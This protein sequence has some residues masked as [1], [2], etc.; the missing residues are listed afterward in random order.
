MITFQMFIYLHAMKQNIYK[1][2]RERRESSFP[3]PR[4]AT[5]P[6]ALLFLTASDAAW[7]SMEFNSLKIKHLESL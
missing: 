3:L 2:F 4:Q 6:I 7:A 5:P 1:V